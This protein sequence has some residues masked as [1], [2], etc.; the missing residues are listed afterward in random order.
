MNMPRRRELKPS[1]LQ[2][3]WTLVL[4]FMVDFWSKVICCSDVSNET[5]EYVC[6]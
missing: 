1:L 4:S 2:S 6:L 3:V 5:D